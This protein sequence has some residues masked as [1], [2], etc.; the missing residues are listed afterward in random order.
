V[1][2]EAVAAACFAIAAFSDPIP[3]GSATYG[4][5]GVT[6]VFGRPTSLSWSAD[7]GLLIATIVLGLTGLATFVVSRSNR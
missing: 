4:P 1:V 6:E 2:Q 7:R 3:R 5:E